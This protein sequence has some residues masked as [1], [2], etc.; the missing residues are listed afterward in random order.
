MTAQPVTMPEAAT[1]VEIHNGIQ[2]GPARVDGQFGARL[3]YADAGRM[4]F[5]VDVVFADGAR[6]TLHDDASYDAAIVEA[7]EAAAEWGV[8]VRDLVRP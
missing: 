6:L 4:K 8:I 3:D 5:W 1:H 2:N 7:E